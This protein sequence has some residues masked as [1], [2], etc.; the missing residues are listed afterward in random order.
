MRRFAV[1]ALALFPA[2]A[3][4]AQEYDG[5]PL[6]AWVEDAANRSLIGACPGGD[7]TDACPGRSASRSEAA[8]AIVKAFEIPT[9]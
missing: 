1:V 5:R 3:V 6:A 8:I 7:E 2:L 9:F 4:Q